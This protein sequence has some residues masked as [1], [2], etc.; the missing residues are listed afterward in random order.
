MRAEFDEGIVTR[1]GNQRKRSLA[2]VLYNRTSS[3]CIRVHCTLDV[4]DTLSTKFFLRFVSFRVLFF[5]QNY[6]CGEKE[7]RQRT[8]LF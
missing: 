5:E 3:T 1:F 7:E 4:D 6:I 8:E 2:A